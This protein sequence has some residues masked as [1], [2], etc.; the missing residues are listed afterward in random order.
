MDFFHKVFAYLDGLVWIKE[1]SISKIWKKEKLKKLLNEGS[2]ARPKNSGELGKDFS[3]ER[4]TQQFL[5]RF[6]L[7]MNTTR[8]KLGWT[9]HLMT[10]L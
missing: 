3:S 6:W 2:R 4:S 1:W 7:M 10:P 9:D 8:R 5:H